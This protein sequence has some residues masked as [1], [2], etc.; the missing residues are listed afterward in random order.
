MAISDG[1]N[2]IAMNVSIA[3]AKNRFTKLI[4]AVEEGEPVLITRRGRPV[5]QIIAAPPQRRK[6][7]FAGMKDQVK[8]LPGWDDPIDPDSFLAGDV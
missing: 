6:V 2:E 3:E 1:Y 7:V 5:A 4:R 8:L